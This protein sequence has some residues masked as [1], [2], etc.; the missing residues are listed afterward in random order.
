MTA[1]VD[2]LLHEVERLAAETARGRRRAASRASRSPA[3]AR[4]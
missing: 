2:E 1:R 3:P 4:A